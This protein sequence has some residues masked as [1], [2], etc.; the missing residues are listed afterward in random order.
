M[1]FVTTVSDPVQDWILNT[2]LQ[3]P[4][5]AAEILHRVFQHV[6]SGHVGKK[7][8]LDVLARDA[9]SA[10]ARALRVQ[11]E[12]RM[13]VHDL[14]DLDSLAGEVGV[15]ADAGSVTVTVPSDWTEKVDLILRTR[16]CPRCGSVVPGVPHSV[17][18]CDEALARDVM[19]S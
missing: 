10:L 18:E 15:S 1:V 4:L 3:D 5:P 13:V 6:S 16:T 11:A 12:M 14:S 9:R 7:L 8:D 19:E 17:E 2:G